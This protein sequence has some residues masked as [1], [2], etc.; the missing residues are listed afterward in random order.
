M[1]KQRNLRKRRAVDDEDDLQ[2]KDDDGQ[3]QIS[4]E[5]IK[6]LQKQRLRKT[7]RLHD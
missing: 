3:M 1:S 4:A 6:L 5:E 7:V 2:E